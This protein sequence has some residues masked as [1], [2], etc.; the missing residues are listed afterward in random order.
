ML[1]T[2]LTLLWVRKFTEKHECVTTENGVET[3]GISN[4]AQEAL[5]DVY[6]SLPEVGTKLNKQ[7]FGAWKV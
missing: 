4:F 3:L 5:G 2:G 1:C 7:E 6:R